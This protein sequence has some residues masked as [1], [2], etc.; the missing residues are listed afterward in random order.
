MSGAGG[1][2]GSPAGCAG[3]A[4]LI[5]CSMVHAETDGVVNLLWPKAVAVLK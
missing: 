3:E 5:S 1:P 2:L 4:M